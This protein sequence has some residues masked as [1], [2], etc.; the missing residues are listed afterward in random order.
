MLFVTVAIKNYLQ[1]KNQAR[2]L[3][4]QRL[5]YYNQFYNFKYYRVSIKDQRSRWGSCSGLGNLN[6]NYRLA[7]LPDELA[8]YIIVHELCHLKEMNHSARFWRLVAQTIPDYLGRRR[9]LKK[10]RIN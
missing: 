2:C 10:I 1:Y 5:E 8:D 9:E 7:S 3:V 6:F 4:R